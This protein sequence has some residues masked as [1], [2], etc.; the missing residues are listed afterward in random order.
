V[1]DGGGRRWAWRWVE[2]DGGG[3]GREWVSREEVGTTA[4]RGGRAVGA[5][6]GEGSVRGISYF[7]VAT[8]ATAGAGRG[9]PFPYFALVGWEW[10]AAGISL[11]DLGRSLP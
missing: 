11:T 6:E 1:V 4:S 2:V 7:A 9:L 8:A 10:E 3:R 5:T